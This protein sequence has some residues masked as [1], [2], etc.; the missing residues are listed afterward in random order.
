MVPVSI[1]SPRH[2][3]W[4]GSHSLADQRCPFHY[5]HVPPSCCVGRAANKGSRV[6]VYQ[7]RERKPVSDDRSNVRSPWELQRVQLMVGVQL[8]TWRVFRFRSYFGR[9]SI[10]R[11]EDLPAGCCP[12]A[13]TWCKFSAV[14]CAKM[15]IAG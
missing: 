13:E 8:P 15:L 2:F 7:R 5:R 12:Y 11:C 6:R 9:R 4:P 14:R 3:G 1:K 10:K